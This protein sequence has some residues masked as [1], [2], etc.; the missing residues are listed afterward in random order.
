MQPR[1]LDQVITSLGS[2]YDPEVQNVRAQ[3]AALPGQLQTDE[4][5][6]QGEQ[7]RA[8]DDI[9][10]GARRRG[11]GVAFGGIP[12]GEQAKYTSTTFLPEMARLRG[13][14]A[15]KGLSLEDAIL[16]IN[17]RRA[18]QG[19]S[20]FENERNFFES[21]RQFDEQQAANERASRAAAASPSFAFPGAGGPTAPAAA[22][23]AGPKFIGN[24][25][26]RGH[27]N[28]LAQKEGNADAR[29][30]LQYVGN[31]GKYS[32]SPYVTNPAIIAALNRIGAVNV[33]KAPAPA[34]TTKAPAKGTNQYGGSTNGLRF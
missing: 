29:I 17:E 10:Q 7:T 33:Y 15:T 25:D 8:F 21:K 14:Y 1:T 27:L 19:Q 24:N 23:P 11:T 6:L 18:Q 16:G 3:Q 5:A 32:L 26:L 2:V 20:I 28:Y 4:T 12:L 30:A 31:D 22:K 13:T 9:L 34:K